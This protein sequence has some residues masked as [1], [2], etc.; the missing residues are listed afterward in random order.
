MPPLH[1]SEPARMKNGTAK[2][3]KESKPVNAFYAIITIG[4]L[5][6]NS[7]MIQVESPSVMPMGM[8]N[9]MVTMRMENIRMASMSLASL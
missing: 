1:I 8:L 5:D 4:M 9:A 7:I 3:G 2:R 6:V